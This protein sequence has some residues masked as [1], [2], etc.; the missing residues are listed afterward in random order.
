MRPIACGFLVAAVFG[1]AACASAPTREAMSVRTPAAK[2][3]PYSVSVQT[4]GGGQTDQVTGANISNEDLKAAVESSIVESKLFRSVA[5]GKDGDYEL[6]VTITQLSKPTFGLSFTVEMETGWALTRASDKTVAIR[7]VVRSSNTATM[8]DAV[9]GGTRM[10]LAI[11]GAVRKNITEGLQ[12]IAALGTLDSP[13]G[14]APEQPVVAT[15][16]GQSS[17]RNLSGEEIAAHFARYASI[18]ARQGRGATFTLLIRPDRTIER[19]CPNCRRQ[20]GSGTMRVKQDEAVV[21]F[22]WRVYYP[23]SGCFKVIQTGATS[24]QL[25][26]VDAEI[27]IRYSVAP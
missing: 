11:E 14:A 2:S 21:C 12:A 8:D 25:R 10:R 5:Q 17:P 24:Y 22:D 6:S 15:P 3:Y 18:E 23:A 4:R 1:L 20:S 13:T 27:V 7:K 26:K 16:P 9:V 19:T